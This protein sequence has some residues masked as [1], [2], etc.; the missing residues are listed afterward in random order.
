MAKECVTT[1][2]R[3]HDI[4]KVALLERA[5][6]SL[7]AQADVL[8][9][10]VIV[11][12]R[13]TL[14]Q[15]RQLDAAV[16]RQW[17][18]DGL[19]EPQILNFTD[20]GDFDARS[21][22]LNHGIARHLELDNRYLA[23]LDYDDLLYTHAYR[24]LTKALRSSG[25][26]IAFATVELAKVISLKDYEFVYSLSTPYTGRNKIDLIKDNFCP[27]HS[28]V[29]DTSKLRP[30]ELYFQ[31]ELVRVED[32]DFLLRI[33]GRHP[34]DFSNIGTRIGLY[35]MRT[36]GTNSTPGGMGSVTE[37]ETGTAWKDSINRL[38]GLRPEY[39]IKFFASDF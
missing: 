19:P 27:L 6:Q 21:M 32:Y 14:D 20:P 24:T 31:K 9:Q 18:F 1:V 3:F 8:V 36:D 33:A 4:E 11:A 2:I 29:V 25:A 17:Y 22:L 39:E 30:D 38:N 28:Y 16:R 37:R 10:P 23:F 13:F 26:V 35:M 15:M 7:H 5:I 34:C 12:Q